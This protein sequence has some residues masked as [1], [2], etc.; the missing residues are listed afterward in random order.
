M[1]RRTPG[2]TIIRKSAQICF[3]RPS[4]KSFNRGMK[5][6][7]QSLAIFCLLAIS[8]GCTHKVQIEPSDKPFV[9]NLNVNID[10][11]I[12]VDI[13]EKN[14]DLLNLEEEVLSE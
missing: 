1:W 5:F 4:Q 13:E 2:R 11:K 3:D 9:V 12:R 10:H 7:Q 8:S 14:Q 6:W